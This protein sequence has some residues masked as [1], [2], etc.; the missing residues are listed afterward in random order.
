MAQVESELTGWQPPSSFLFCT[1]TCKMYISDKAV[2]CD[3][4]ILFNPNIDFY[5]CQVAALVEELIGKQ[6]CSSEVV[7]SGCSAWG[8]EGMWQREYSIPHTCAYV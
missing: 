5:A 6:K 4:K 8:T 3:N 1:E 2:K 7:C